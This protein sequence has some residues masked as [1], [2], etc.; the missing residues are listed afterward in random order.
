MHAVACNLNMN[1]KIESFYPQ[2]GQ[3][4]YDA[5]PTFSEAWLTFESIED[6]WGTESFY[7]TYDGCIHYKNDDLEEVEKLLRGMRQTFIESNLSP[8]TQV[9]FHLFETG[10]FSIEFGYDDVSDFGLTGER[11][12]IWM[13]NTFGKDVEIQWV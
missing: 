8:F 5:L 12:T 7:K 9:V 2:L 1:E 10:K 6:V 3:S 4:F 11:R 13:K